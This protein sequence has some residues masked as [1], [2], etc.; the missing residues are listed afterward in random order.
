MLGRFVVGEQ[1]LFVI[2]NEGQGISQE[3]LDA[4]DSGVLIP[5]TDAA[6]SLN[7]SIA[8]AVIMWE[9]VRNRA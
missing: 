2:G 6:E 7:A 3:L 5:M 9:G 4:C 1:D 8:A